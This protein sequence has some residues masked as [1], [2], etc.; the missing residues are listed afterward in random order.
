MRSDKFMFESFKVASLG[1]VDSCMPHFVYN[2]MI[3]LFFQLSTSRTVQLI[4]LLDQ[5]V[6][7]LSIVQK[8]HDGNMQV[9]YHPIPVNLCKV[10]YHILSIVDNFGLYL[11]NKVSGLCTIW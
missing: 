1:S 4:D 11:R 10:C 8:G 7:T 6:E 2:L 5:H 9:I 3:P